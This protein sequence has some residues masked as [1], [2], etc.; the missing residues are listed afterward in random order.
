MIDQALKHKRKVVII[1]ALVLLG[2]G[3]AVF[4]LT[5]DSGLP[6][7]VQGNLSA[8]DVAQIE[9]AVRHELWREAFPNCS[10]ATFKALPH[11]VKRVLKTRVTEVSRAGPLPD[12]T[13]RALARISEPFDAT[14]SN[15]MNSIAPGYLLTNGLTGW[16]VG[17][18]MHMHL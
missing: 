6:V 17:I 1:I 16:S 18:R 10:W 4:L 7:V 5:R 12:G 3:I 13:A 8:K 15:G 2:A 14:T 11:E 9:R